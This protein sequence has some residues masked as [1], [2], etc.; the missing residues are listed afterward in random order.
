MRLGFFFV[1]TKCLCSS[2]ADFVEACG[3]SATMHEP[4]WLKRPGSRRCKAPFVRTAAGATRPIIHRQAALPI[5]L[6]EATAACRRSPHSGS[7]PVPFPQE[8]QDSAPQNL[9]QRIDVPH[10]SERP[11]RKLSPEGNTDPKKDRQGERSRQ[12]LS[13]AGN[14]DLKNATPLADPAGSGPGCVDQRATNLQ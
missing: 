2:V 14:T 4:N 8:L 9:P 10:H 1:A 12:M 7:L 13:P 6:L 5:Q 11:R 3:P